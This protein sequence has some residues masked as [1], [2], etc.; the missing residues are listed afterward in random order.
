MEMISYQFGQLAAAALFG[1]LLGLYYDGYSLFLA[2]TRLKGWGRAVLDFLWWVS[3]FAVLFLF[4]YL[5]LAWPIRMGLLLWLAL[6]FCFYMAFFHGFFM[7]I[8][9]RLLAKAQQLPL[10]KLPVEKWRLFAAKP[11]DDFGAWVFGPARF[12]WRGLDFS[13]QGLR[14]AAKGWRRGGAGLRA[15]LGRLFPFRKK[16]SEDDLE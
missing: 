14:Y 13:R 12:F 1:L 10:K 7:L 2:L 6:G 16:G 9:R 11:L 4:W 5:V 3:A 8:R 15:G